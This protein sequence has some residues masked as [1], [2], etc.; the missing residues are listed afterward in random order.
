MLLLIPWSFATLLLGAFFAGGA[1]GWPGE[2]VGAGKMFCESFGDGWIKQ[3]ANT[4]SNLGFVA[5][6]LWMVSYL[7]IG[8]RKNWFAGNRFSRSPSL[9]ILYAL[10]VIF[11]GPGSMALHGTGHAWGHTVDVLAMFTFIMFPIAWSATHLLRGEDRTF[12]AIYLA[13]TIPLTLA[14]VF[15][16]LPFSGIALYAVLIPTTIALEVARYICRPTGLRSLVLTGCA[17]GSFVL[18]FTAWRLSI[19]GAPLCDP[20]SLVQ[21]HALWHLLCAFTTV[22]L[23]LAY[24]NER[25][26]AAATS[27]T[28][29]Q[30]TKT[31]A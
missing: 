13:V 23:F 18:A 14:H 21:G 30:V 5:A 20:G 22:Y 10:L 7:S 17:L 28:G 11:I 29:I 15:G 9:P 2:F 26:E 12:W 6:G 24:L 25:P 1:F 16:V 27:R 4:W 31:N 19:S 3:P 8:R